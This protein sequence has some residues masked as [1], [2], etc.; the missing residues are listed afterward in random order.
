MRIDMISMK[1]CR[2]QNSDCCREEVNLE[3]MFET[4]YCESHPEHTHHTIF[5]YFIKK[6]N[7]LILLVLLH[8]LV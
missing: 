3:S 4:D 6:N 5:S 2:P 8:G 1:S 7:F